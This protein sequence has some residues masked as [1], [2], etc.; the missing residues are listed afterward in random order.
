MRKSLL[1]NPALQFLIGRSIG[2]YMLFVGAT[3][4]WEQVNRAAIE[5]FLRGESPVVGCIWHGRFTLVHKMWAFGP[6]IPK[7]KMLISQSREGGIVAHASL[8]VGAEVIRGSAPKKDGRAKGGAEA[9]RAMARHI[10]GGG[11]IC[12]TPDGPK[13]PRMRA[14]KA[15]VQLA[16]LAQAPLIAVTWASSRRKLFDSWDR[17]VLPLPFGRGVLIWSDPI[18]PPRPDA[19][20]AEIEAVRARLEAEMN[21]IAAEADR[22]AGVAVIEPAAPRETTPQPAA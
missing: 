10:E 3:T 16:K 14:K 1:S 8:T 13:G 19:E 15:P 21:R 22:R 4:R 18:A 11:V 17:F 7:A 6:G 12:M 9:L 2:L 20:D 5:P